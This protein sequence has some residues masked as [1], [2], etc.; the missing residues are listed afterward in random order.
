MLSDYLAYRERV[1]AFLSRHFT[2][3]CTQSCYQSRRSACCA[4]EGIV[5]F[6]AD[7]VINVLCSPPKDIDRIITALKQPNTGF[8]C[9]Y[10]T[11]NGCLWKV[12]PIVCAMFLCDAALRS[13]FEVNPTLQY[14][15]EAL[16]DEKNRFTWPDRPVLFDDME[17]YF[18]KA[19][20]T[21]S[22][23]Y[24]HNSPGLLRIKKN[25]QVSSPPPETSHGTFQKTDQSSDNG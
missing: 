9:I 5:T 18:I 24:L 11:P 8:K 2:D 6:F 16:R 10:L 7:V 13:V 20:Y 19:K 15:W 3:V 14:E 21:S 23:M 1:D 12:K 22:L 4:R 25:R 17:A